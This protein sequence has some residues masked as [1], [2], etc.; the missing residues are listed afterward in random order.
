MGQLT[1]ELERLASE[2][3]SVCVTSM[4]SHIHPPH[5]HHRHG[6]HFRVSRRLP[7]AGEKAEGIN[8]GEVGKQTEDNR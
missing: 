3:Y 7:S 6:L 1:G 5:H 8:E 2:D 4:P